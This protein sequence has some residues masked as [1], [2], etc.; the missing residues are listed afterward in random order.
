MEDRVDEAS[1]IL[2]DIETK[3]VVGADDSYVPPE[4]PIQ[5]AEIRTLAAIVAGIL[6]VLF[7]LRL[8]VVF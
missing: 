1:E 3:S 8:I 7:A 2:L 5:S 6:A 4:R